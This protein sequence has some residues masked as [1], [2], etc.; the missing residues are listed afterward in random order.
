MD[1]I[2]NPRFRWFAWAVAWGMIPVILWGA[3]VRTSKSG[4]GCGE[5][6]PTCKGEVF[7]LDASVETTIEFV[8][9]AMSGGLGVLVVILVVWA[10]RVA[11][12][13]H[14]IRK[15]AM[16]TFVFIVAEGAIGAALVLFGLTGEDPRPV[17]G[18][19]IALHLV[20][21]FILVAF[22]VLTAHFAGGGPSLRWRGVGGERWQIAMGLLLLLL[23]SA[24]GAVTALGDTLFPIELKL[25]DGLLAHLEEELSAGQHLLVRL[26][27]IHPILAM[28]S[29][30]YLL[31]L[32]NALHRPDASEP[33]RAWSARLALI[34]VVQVVVGIVNIWMAA[35]TWLQ[36]TH[37]AVADLLWIVAVMLTVNVL[38]D[39]T[40][41]SERKHN[42]S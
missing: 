20:N 18:L 10:W 27:I 34:V 22:S 42:P 41:S 40:A 15:A 31:W 4:A 16:A 2:P 36:L 7:P 19:V 39:T 11:P 28:V 8:H 12:P 17:R 1:P 6:W 26:R 25:E 32:A 13:G 21:T 3:F 24:T 38:A 5:H 37:L 30:L 35:P 9:R 14:R 29:T 23:T 33:V